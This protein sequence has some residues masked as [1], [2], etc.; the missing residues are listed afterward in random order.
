MAIDPDVQVLLDGINSR[1]DGLLTVITDPLV[2]DEPNTVI[3]GV[4]FDGSQAGDLGD[5]AFIT[6]KAPNVRIVDCEIANV[7][8]H[9]IETNS[10][11]TEVAGTTFTNVSR[12]GVFAIARYNQPGF[13]GPSVLN[14]RFDNCGFE[15]T[16]VVAFRALGGDIVGG[17]VSDNRF[18][19]CDGEHIWIAGDQANIHT[20]GVVVDGNLITEPGPNGPYISCTHSSRHCVVSNNMVVGGPHA[21]YESGNH[22]RDNLFTGNVSIRSGASAYINRSAAGGTTRA[23]FI[24]NVAIEPAKFGFVFGEQEPGGIW[25]HNT[26]IDPGVGVRLDL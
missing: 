8:G 16:I 18:V 11:G 14:N 5:S 23:H 19:R 4:R 12:A 9:A 3:R 25:E 1:I 10:D 7:T 6:V 22:D 15:Q 20:E 17:Q 2:I 24:G 26:V 21:H 13:A